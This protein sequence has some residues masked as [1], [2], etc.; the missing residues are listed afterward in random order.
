MKKL[1]EKIIVM[2]EKCKELQ[3]KIKDKKSEKP[4]EQTEEVIN[5]ILK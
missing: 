2:E 4:S 1:H 5:P 3:K